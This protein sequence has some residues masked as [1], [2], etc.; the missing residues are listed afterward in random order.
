MVQ[1]RDG[2]SL[3]LGM[4]RS[5]TNGVTV[6]WCC[7]WSIPGNT[8]NCFAKNWYKIQ[9]YTTQFGIEDTYQ[10]QINSL[11]CCFSLDI[12]NNAQWILKGKWKVRL[13]HINHI[14]H[15]GPCVESYKTIKDQSL[16]IQ[17]LQT[18][19]DNI[20]PEKKVHMLHHLSWQIVPNRQRAEEFVC[21]SASKRG[22]DCTECSRTC[23]SEH[24]RW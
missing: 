17:L 1:G 18:Q 5:L 19:L 16:S 24:S 6:I 13:V 10:R 2:M 4:Q 8:G 22:F 21:E 14:A 7:R 23:S 9:A 3:I 12:R 15:S 11:G 20:H